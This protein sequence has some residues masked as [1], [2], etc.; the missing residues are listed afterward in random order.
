MTPAERKL[1]A[2][3][4]GALA[5]RFS[6]SGHPMQMV[7]NER[8]GYCSVKGCAPSCVGLRELFLDAA[9]VLEAEMQQPAQVAM[10]DGEAAI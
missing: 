3:L 5:E 8:L 4:V 1:F 9:E 10:F 7:T 2:G 6:T